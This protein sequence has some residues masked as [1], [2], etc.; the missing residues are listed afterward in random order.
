MMAGC[1]EPRAAFGAI[2]HVPRV[3][4]LS[5]EVPRAAP[6]DRANGFSAVQS[7]PGIRADWQGGFCSHFSR[8]G[9]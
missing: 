4:G 1:A 8:C 2:Q 7:F 6:G 9:S 3:L 5:A